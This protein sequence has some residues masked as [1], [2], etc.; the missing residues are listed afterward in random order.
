MKS[1]T[2]LVCAG[3]VFAMVFMMG[4][5]KHPLPGNPPAQLEGAGKDAHKDAAKDAQKAH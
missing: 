4:C 1:T 2:V 5:E 3:I